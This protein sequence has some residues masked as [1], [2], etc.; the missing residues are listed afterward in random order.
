MKLEEESEN[1]DQTEGSSRNSVE[2]RNN[3]DNSN[4]FKQVLVLIDFNSLSCLFLL[5]SLSCLR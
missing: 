2:T 1:N 4:L 5:H 3:N